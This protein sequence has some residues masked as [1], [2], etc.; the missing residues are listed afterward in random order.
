MNELVIPQMPVGLVE[1]EEIVAESNLQVIAS[2]GQFR[3]AFVMAR[4]IRQIEKLISDEMMVDIMAL[5]G[6]P[7][8]FRTDKDRGGGYPVAAVKSAFIEA[9]LRGVR[10]VGNEFN[11]IAQ[12]CYITKE[13]FSRLVREW[14]GLTDLQL[15][16]GVPQTSTGG[17]LVPFRAKWKLRGEQRELARVKTETEDFRIPVK[18]NEGMGADAILG[19]ATRKMLAG[20][21]GVLT[22][23]NEAVPEGEVEEFSVGAG[24]RA[25]VSQLTQKIANGN[26]GA[27][28]EQELVAA[29]I[30]E[31]KDGKLFDG[32]PSAQ[33]S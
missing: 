10:A 11:I 12:R 8:G 19:K 20:I 23:A 25:R 32:T 29:G 13:G 6:T 7:L 5:Q 3:Q 16:P 9:T 30:N 27:P 4:A 26:G 33:E 22:G 28:T 15:M 1:M 24:S 18:V 21:Y 31:P 2:Y 17:A 14:P